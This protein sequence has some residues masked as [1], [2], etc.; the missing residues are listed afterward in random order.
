MDVNVIAQLIG[1]VG[2]PIVCCLMM[3]W[4]INKIEDR[5][6]EDANKAED[7]YRADVDK[8]S[9]IIMNNTEAMT[10]LADKIAD[11][12]NRLSVSGEG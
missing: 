4:Y 3:G 2:F 5:Y 7:R 10:K 9:E 8:L 6:R 11:M 1:S 12:E